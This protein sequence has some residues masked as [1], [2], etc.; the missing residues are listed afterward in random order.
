VQP[1]CQTVAGR[2]SAQLWVESSG[3]LAPELDPRASAR[4]SAAASTSAIADSMVEVTEPVP[5]LVL[6]P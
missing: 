4:A 2:A 1:V 5:P 3:R 6:A